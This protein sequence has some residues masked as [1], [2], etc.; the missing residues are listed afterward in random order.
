VKACAAGLA[1]TYVNNM[2]HNE[3][4]SSIIACSLVA[5]ETMC[6]ESC[7]IATAVV[8]SPVYKA[9]TWQEV[10]MSHDIYNKIAKHRVTCG[11]IKVSQMR[12]QL[13]RLK[14]CMCL[15]GP[16]YI[17]LWRIE[18]LLGKDLETKKKNQATAVA[19]HRR[20]KHASTTTELVLE[21]VL[22]QPLLG[23]CNRN[24]Y[25]ESYWG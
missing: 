9:V 16:S 15:R 21:T 25:Y 20:G 11:I 22:M 3:N 19:M 6:P 13:Q 7:S 12:S 17:I 18:P 2:D 1:L 24:E 4:T 5:G 8:L 10:C 14:S 23:S